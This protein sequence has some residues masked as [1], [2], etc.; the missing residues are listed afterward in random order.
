[1]AEMLGFSGIKN[2]ATF[3]LDDTT[4]EAIKDN[5]K[6]IIGKAV[7]MVDNYT[8]GYGSAGATPLGFVEQVEP[9]GNGNTDWVVSVVF[10]VSAEDIPCVG[11]ETAG[12]YAVC[13]GNG[14]LK[15]GAD[16]KCTIWGVDTDN[17]VCTAYISG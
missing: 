15:K 12:D 17:K 14:G 10:N 2:G 9:M 6:D 1:M 8:V 4:K 5:P 11:T 3:M 7:A 16:P 13:D